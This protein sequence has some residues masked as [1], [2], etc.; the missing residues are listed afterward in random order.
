MKIK[1]CLSAV[2]LILQI[3]GICQQWEIEWQK[4]MG[5]PKNDNFCKVMEDHE[6]NLTVLGASQDENKVFNFWLVKFDSKGNLLWTKTFGTDK[7]DYPRCLTIL[8]DGS[9][10]L[11]GNTEG[12]QWGTQAVIIKTDSLG[13]EIWQKNIGNE[14][15]ISAENII[16]MDEGGFLVSGIKN[17]EEASNNIFLIRFNG[18]GEVIWE[19]VINKYKQACSRSLKRLPNGGIVM[20]G[21]T[22][23]SGN[24]NNANVLIAMYSEE[25]ELI[26][27]KVIETPDKNVWPECI[28]CSPDSNLVVI[29]WHGTCMNDI[30]S[31]NPVFDYDLFLAKISPEGK[32]LWTK[33][34]DSEGSE[35]GNAIIIRPGGEI[36]LAGKKETSFLG[37]IGPWLILTDESG[38][39]LGELVLPFKFNGDQVADLINTADNGFVVVGPGMIRDNVKQSDGWIRKFK[40]F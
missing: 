5:S 32:I 23:M 17:N 1:L 21:S 39:I 33:N 36:L 20:A 6:R 11:S 34:I 2:F 27:E 19:K 15:Y 7:N 4:Y 3:P 12:G 24:I 31:E 25:G 14:N 40:S 8:T 13:N 26:W 16:S 29:G 30:T 9:Y 37:R 18:N 28:C 22:L 10:V 35:G 38:K